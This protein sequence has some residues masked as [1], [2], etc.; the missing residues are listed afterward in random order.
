MKAKYENGGFGYGHAKQELFELVLSRF[1]D[2]RKKYNYLMSNK[3]EIDSILNEGAK[4]ASITANKVMNR[5]RKKL[6][7]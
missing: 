4:K 1:N 5:V 3:K 7:Y 6:G 2:E